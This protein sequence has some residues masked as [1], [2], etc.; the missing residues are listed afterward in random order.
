MRSVQSGGNE[1]LG[2]PASVRPGARPDAL[3]KT[4]GRACSRNAR[5]SCA[6]RA[7]IPP[8]GCTVGIPTTPFCRSITT[9]AGMVSRCVSGIFLV[10]LFICKHRARH[11]AD[12]SDAGEEDDQGGVVSAGNV[13]DA[14]QD[15]TDD[16]VEERPEHVHGWG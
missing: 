11:D 12:G 16:Q 1:N 13:S 6:V 8:I 14:E 9:R 2:A 15:V 3:T 4:T 5:A 10:G 7:M